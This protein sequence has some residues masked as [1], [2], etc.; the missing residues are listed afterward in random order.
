MG[1][2]NIIHHFDKP[3]KSQCPLKWNKFDEALMIP[4]KFLKNSSKKRKVI[5]RLKKQNSHSEKLLDRNLLSFQDLNIL[6][7]TIYHTLKTIELEV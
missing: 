7:D 6:D 4:D 5:L 1:I 2:E 3:Y